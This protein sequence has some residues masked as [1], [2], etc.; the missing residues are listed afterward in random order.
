MGEVE[1]KKKSNRGFASLSPER[2]REIASMGGKKAQELGTANRWTAETAK[3]AGQKGGLA[4]AGRTEYLSEIGKRG[5]LAL[6][7]KRRAKKA[8]GTEE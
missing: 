7:A 1:G 3:S 8:E 5:G 6:Q 2:R 4:M